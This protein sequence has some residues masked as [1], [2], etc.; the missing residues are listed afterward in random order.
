MAKIPNFE[1]DHYSDGDPIGAQ[2]ARRVSGLWDKCWSANL[3][4]MHNVQVSS[5]V[6]PDKLKPD[7]FLYMAG[8]ESLDDSITFGTALIFTAENVEQFAHV[9]VTCVNVVFN[10]RQGK[11]QWWFVCRK[12]WLD[13]TAPDATAKLARLI[14][15]VAGDFTMF[16]IE[17]G[18]GQPPVLANELAWEVWHEQGN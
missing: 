10:G 13:G 9:C 4:Y 7:D 11:A 18:K 16:L 8:N 12:D 5:E 6:R 17:A 1:S 15:R 3:P 2:I 14:G